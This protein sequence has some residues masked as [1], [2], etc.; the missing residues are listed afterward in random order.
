MYELYL[1]AIRAEG[2]CFFLEI[3]THGHPLFAFSSFTEVSLRQSLHQIF[4]ILRLVL[5]KLFD[6]RI[7]L[8]LPAS[9]RQQKVLP[10][11][12]EICILSALEHPVLIVTHFLDH[13]WT[14]AVKLVYKVLILFIHFLHAFCMT[15]RD[16]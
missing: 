16:F 4:F 3:L 8:L 9:L 6:S 10:T 7:F 15:H 1:I 5:L 2:G 14:L 12:G 13:R 11:L